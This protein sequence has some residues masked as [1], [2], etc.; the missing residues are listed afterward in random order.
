MKSEISG[1][2]SVLALFTLLLLAST[3]HAENGGLLQCLMSRISPAHSGLASEV[4]TQHKEITRRLIGKGLMR[5]I[6]VHHDFTPF[7][8]LSDF[9]DA[10]TAEKISNLVDF[11]INGYE[12]KRGNVTGESFTIIPVRADKPIK[13]EV[14]L[15]R[16]N[17]TSLLQVAKTK[18][19]LPPWSN[20]S[21]TKLLDLMSFRMTYERPLDKEIED[22]YLS[23]LLC[24]QEDLAQLISQPTSDALYTLVKKHGSPGWFDICINLPQIKPIDS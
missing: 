5:T 12:I 8:E 11:S 1:K 24:E 23:S 6:K 2:R 19:T 20:S 9:I 18:A 13:I 17:A 14:A 10:N 16:G 4:S 15:N 3:I 22:Y 21:F 7:L